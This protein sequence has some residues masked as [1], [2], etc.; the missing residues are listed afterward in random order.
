MNVQ[1]IT[2]CEFG[3]KNLDTM[4]VISAGMDLHSPQQYPAGFMMQVT[5]LGSKGLEMHKIM[6]N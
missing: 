5:N 1:Q 6:M 2:G 3:G 4:Y